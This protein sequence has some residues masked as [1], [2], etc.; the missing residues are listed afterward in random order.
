[1]LGFD[2]FADNVNVTSNEYPTLEA[3]TDAAIAAATSHAARGAVVRCRSAVVTFNPYKIT[4][5]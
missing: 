2:V 4:N 5:L 1:M 3:A